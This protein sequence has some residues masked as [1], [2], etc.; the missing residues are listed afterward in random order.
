MKSQISGSLFLRDIGD[1]NETDINNKLKFMHLI[2]MSCDEKDKLNQMYKGGDYSGVIKI[3][4]QN[5]SLILKEIFNEIVFVDEIYKIEYIPV[6]KPKTIKQ[7]PKYFITSNEIVRGLDIPETANKII[8]NP[9]TIK[10][11]RRLKSA[12]TLKYKDERNDTLKNV[13]KFVID[14]IENAPFVLRNG[15][16][17]TS[18]GDGIDKLKY[19]ELKRTFDMFV[20]KISVLLS[21]K[22]KIREINIQSIQTEKENINQKRKQFIDNRSLEEIE[23]SMK[24]IMDKNTNV[25]KRLKL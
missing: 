9:E 18:V 1:V 23:L 16:L 7:Y 14:N 2:K 5:C 6:C 11:M 8:W 19:K 15:T 3:M 13:Y 22:I 24:N 10:I 4:L 20:S 25:L 21:E 17:P 12:L